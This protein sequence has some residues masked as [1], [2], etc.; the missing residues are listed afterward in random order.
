MK[1]STI[2]LGLLSVA[3]ARPPQNGNQ[4][5]LIIIADILNLI[6]YNELCEQVC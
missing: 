6:T 5:Q 2:L 4:A 3:L 1:R